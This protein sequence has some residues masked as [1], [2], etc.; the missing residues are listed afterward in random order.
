MFCVSAL[1]KRYLYILCCRQGQVD[2]LASHIQAEAII[3]TVS[4]HISQ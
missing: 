3:T 2:P 4:L 1:V